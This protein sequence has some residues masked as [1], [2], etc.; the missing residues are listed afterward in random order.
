[1]ICPGEK[2][3]TTLDGFK[4]LCLKTK[5][6]LAFVL[7]ACIAGLIGGYGIMQMNNI[8]ASSAKIREYEALP[9]AAL[10]K[11]TGA[12]EQERTALRDLL[13][14]KNPAEIKALNASLQGLEQS[15]S[16][17]L[18]LLEKTAASPAEKT[19]VGLLKD[20]RAVYSSRKDKAIQLALKNGQEEAAKI[21]RNPQTEKSSGSL[22]D[23][24]Q[25]LMVAK[26]I[27]LEKASATN[28]ALTGSSEKS[29]LI[30]IFMGMLFAIGL[31]FLINRIVQ[32]QLGDDPK[33]VAEIARS[34]AARNCS[35]NSAATCIPADTFSSATRKR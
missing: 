15:I 10:G 7:A 18:S 9:V 3:M 35:T 29:S 22:T 26:S 1:M 16:G 25:K 23:V 28:S 20:T 6:Y 8:D 17:S 12:L 34:V 19:Q 2:N 33:H 13:T 11:M 4:Q 14:T 31:G 24:V 5:I 32:K 21:L 30:V 27:R